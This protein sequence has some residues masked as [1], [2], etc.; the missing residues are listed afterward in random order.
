[1]ADQR[2][3]AFTGPA[4]ILYV[5][6]TSALAKV[7][8]HQLGEPQNILMIS[9]GSALCGSGFNEII[10]DGIDVASIESETLEWLEH[11]Q[12]RLYP[13]GMIRTLSNG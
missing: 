3:S 1:M 11:L 6:A 4:D 8:W 9:P 2:L 5:C 12:C 7:R 10:L 13:G